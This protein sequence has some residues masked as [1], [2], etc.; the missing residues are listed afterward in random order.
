M[1]KHLAPKRIIVT[2]TLTPSAIAILD[3][4]QRE[5]IMPTRSATLE[6]VVQEWGKARGK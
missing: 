2:V 4:A 1:G 5:E 6:K 3:D